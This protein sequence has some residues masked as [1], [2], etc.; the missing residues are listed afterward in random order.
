MYIYVYMCMYVYIYIFI[1]IYIC[2][3]M[4]K[5]AST[6]VDNNAT[7]EVNDA[8]FVQEATSPNPVTHRVVDEE[9]PEDD[10]NDKTLP[11]ET[12]RKRAR[13]EKRS[14]SCEHHLEKRE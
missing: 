10:E 5:H 8:P 14:N 13:H 12:F 4:P 6:H 9:L 3:N 11:F 1:Y 7:S 2:S